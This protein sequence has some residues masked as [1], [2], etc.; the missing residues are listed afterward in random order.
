M[1][2]KLKLSLPRD[3]GY[4]TIA[5]LTASSIAAKVGFDYEVIEDIKLSI[6]EA[7]NFALFSDR[8]DNYDLEYRIGDDWV[9]V[10]LLVDSKMVHP[11]ETTD[12]TVDE[13]GMGLFII[14]TLM[15]EVEITHSDESRSVLTMRKR[16]TE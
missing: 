12:F 2:D 14:K 16:L 6:S 1:E 3:T 5:R 15:D 8:D 9:E 11:A 10:S 13:R 4:V 7:C